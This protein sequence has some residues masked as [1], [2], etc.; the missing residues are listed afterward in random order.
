MTQWKDT[1]ESIPQAELDKLNH[2]G[3]PALYDMVQVMMAHQAKVT[4]E[5]LAKYVDA[6]RDTLDGLAQEIGIPLIDI[7]KHVHTMQE[8]VGHFEYQVE[9]LEDSIVDTGKHLKDL[10]EQL[11]DAQLAVLA[12][13]QRDSLIHSIKSINDAYTLLVSVKDQAVHKANEADS[14]AKVTLQQVSDRNIQ[15]EAAVTAY[16]DFN[17]QLSWQMFEE[18]YGVERDKFDLSLVFKAL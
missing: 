2:I 4:S 10:E 9:W 18:K 12:Q 3:T 1:I 13:F 8:N 15:L 16:H 17:G 6:A 5:A 11:Q 7:I 14:E